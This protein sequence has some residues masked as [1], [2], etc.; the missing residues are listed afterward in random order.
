M[1]A[2][3]VGDNLIRHWVTHPVFF[4][5]I[6]Q[7]TNGAWVKFLRRFLLASNSVLIDLHGAG[8]RAA[9]GIRLHFRVHGHQRVVLAVD[10]KI[11]AEVVDM[12]V[13]GADNIMVDQRAVAGI[14]FGARVVHGLRLYAFDRFDA[15]RPGINADGAVFVEYPVKD[16]VVV[17][18]GADP[19]HHQLAALGADVRFAHLQVLILR[20]GV[21][22][23]DGDRARDSGWRAGIVGDG[24]IQQHR[25]GRR[26]FPADDRRGQGAHAVVAGIQIGFKIPAHVRVAVG[27]DHPAERSFIHHLALFTVVVPGHGRQNRPDAGVHP[28]ME[29]PVTPV[30]HIAGDGVVFALWLNDLQRFHRWRNAVA[31]VIGAGR[32]RHRD[33][34]PLFDFDDLLLLEVDHRHQVFNRVRPVVPVANVK[35]AHYFEQPRVLLEAIFTVEVADGQRGGNHLARVVD[36]VFFQHFGKL[37]AGVDDVLHAGEI[38]QQYHAVGVFNRRP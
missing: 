32:H 12:L 15:G 31:A 5:G 22:F 18:D 25:V 26:V 37:A 7:Q 33:R 34:R 35:I 3:R 1:R 14:L 8:A 24:F 13:G 20:P 38:I 36:A 2:A 29:I 10:V 4:G 30:D 27:D 11:E 6:A 21:A 23:E 19:A 16:V 28:Q 9:G 17:A